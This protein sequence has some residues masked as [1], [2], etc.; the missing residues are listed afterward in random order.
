MVVP[1]VR[2]ISKKS[3]CIVGAG[4]GV[5]VARGL[6]GQDELGR[7]DEGARQ[8]DA[9]LLAARKLAGPVRRAR[10]ARPTSV[11]QR[12]RRAVHLVGAL[13]L[14]EPGHHHVLERGEL[15]EQVMELEDEPDGAVAE[16]GELARLVTPSA[17]MSSPAS[18]IEPEVGRSSVPMQWR[19]VLLPA[20][21]G[22][23]MATT[24]PS[25]MSRL[26]PR[27]TSSL[28]PMWSNDL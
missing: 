27:S 8:R 17:V 26:M 18:V 3:S 10:S 11:E 21:D 13:A 9:L 25:S 14:D 23:T 5:E 7:E 1:R 19:S 15:G 4:R 22:P 16:R 12:A 20:P 2:L 24:S 6:V 28:R